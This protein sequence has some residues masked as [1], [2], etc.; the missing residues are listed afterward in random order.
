MQRVYGIRLWA[1]TVVVLISRM[2]PAAMAQEEPASE[3]KVATVNGTVITK[4]EY[5]R[6]LERIRQQMMSM[7]R[8]LSDSQFAQIKND[9]LENLIEAELLYQESQEEGFSVDD[10]AIDD[11]MAALRKQF[12]NETEFEETLKKMNISEAEMKADFRRG[13]SIEKLLEDR[14]IG[15][16]AVSE[17]DARGYYDENPD[18]FKQP[19]QVRA[20]HILIKVEADAADSEKAKAREELGEIQQKIKGGADFADLAK[21]FSQGPSGANGGDLGYFGRGQMVPPFE[22][23]AFE[24]KP[25]EVSDIV[26]TRFGYHL[27]KLIEKKNEATVAYDEVKERLE[28]FLKQQKTQQEVLLYIKSL[29]ETAKVER[30]QT[31]ESQ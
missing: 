1:I 4:A 20:S 10:A 5:D 31:Q 18:L 17:E 9:V 7:G 13:K 26:E 23:V 19:E 21:E 30:L 28:L 14:V 6:E 15:K 3:Q 24:L 29:K 2:A 27:V 22:K 11:H 12:P 8:P 25:G 16:I